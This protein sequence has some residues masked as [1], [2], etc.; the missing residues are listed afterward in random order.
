MHTHIPAYVYILIHIHMPYTHTY[1]H[2][3]THTRIH[4]NEAVHLTDHISWG[5]I[6]SSVETRRNIH[7]FL[8]DLFFLCSKS[9]GHQLAVCIGVDGPDRV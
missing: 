2:T 9:E 8:E 1:A 3:Y 4:T 7:H 6:I 5:F